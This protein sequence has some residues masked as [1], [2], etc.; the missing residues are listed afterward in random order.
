MFG[1]GEESSR[2]ERDP[3]GA[4]A[5]R[6]GLPHMPGD[7][8]SRTRWT[9]APRPSSAEPAA[10]ALAPPPSA[11]HRLRRVSESLT[12]TIRELQTFTNAFC[13]QGFPPPLPFL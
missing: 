9:P 1:K 7:L 5:P 10:G 6:R 3:E 8:P 11:Q 4:R 13:L 2:R 12:A